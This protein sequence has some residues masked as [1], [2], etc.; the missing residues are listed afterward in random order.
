MSKTDLSQAEWTAL[1]ILVQN[2]GAILVYNVPDRTETDGLGAL[3]PGM[4][5]YKKLDRKGLAVITEEDPTV[6]E[7]GF[8]FTFSPMI[9]ITDAGK[10]AA[11]KSVS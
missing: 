3:D 9:E 11:Q 7:D 10:A 4:G 6:F 1:Q 5:V 2:G 8:E